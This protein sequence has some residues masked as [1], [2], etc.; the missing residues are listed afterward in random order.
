VNAR[1]GLR[2]LARIVQTSHT[3][4]VTAAL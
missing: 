1:I 3:G 2:V 4:S